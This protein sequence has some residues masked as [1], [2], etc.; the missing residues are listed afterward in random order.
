M[1][2]DYLLFKEVETPSTSVEGVSLFLREAN[3]GADAEWQEQQGLSSASAIGSLL[4]DDSPTLYKAQY[5]VG[6]D[7]I[8]NNTKIQGADVQLFP[9]PLKGD[10]IY[11]RGL[12]EEARL[13]IYN[14]GGKLVLQ[15][16]VTADQASVDIKTL[17]AGN[18]FYAIQGENYFLRGKLNIQ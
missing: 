8:S 7:G 2:T 1:N 13:S 17:A 6:S 18:Y 11:L 3:S 15:K 10:R 9:N 4:F 5:S 16:T 14:L 12:K